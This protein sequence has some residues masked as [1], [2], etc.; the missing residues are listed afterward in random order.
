MNQTWEIFLALFKI[1]GLDHLSDETKLNTLLL[2]AFAPVF[3]FMVALYADKKAM[4]HEDS[5]KSIKAE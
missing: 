2:M 5:E 1:I 3:I 4:R